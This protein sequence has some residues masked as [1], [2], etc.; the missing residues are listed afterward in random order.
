MY[1]G[2][3]PTAWNRQVGSGS[4]LKRA[5]LAF[6]AMLAVSNGGALARA[7]TPVVSVQRQP[8]T[9]AGLAAGHA[10]EAWLQLDKSNEP[11]EPGY[12]LPA[13]ATIRFTF[14]RRFSP[15]RDLPLQVV[16]LHGWPQ[17]PITAKFD[18][19]LDPRDSRAIILRLSDPIAVH[20]PDQPGLKAIHLRAPVGNPAQ[21]GG[22]PVV[23]AFEGAG[24]LSGST[25]AVAHISAKPIPNIAAYNQLHAGGN[26]NWQ[27]VKVG[28]EA[29]L[30]LDWLVTLPNE[31]RASLALLPAR[32][33]R[34]TIAA[35]GKPIGTIRSSGAS[36]TLRAES[37]GVGFARLGIIRAHVVAGGEAGAAE[38]EAKLDGG[39]RYV[40][41]LIIEP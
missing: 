33:G 37:L 24:A 36:L 8:M 12:Q 3:N 21:P 28:Q 26:E 11:E 6:I 14:P 9:A 18:V 32:D 22:Y 30:P 19:Y 35:D 39:A 41:H 20:P 2:A 17:G 15:K 4:R 31:A 29:P 5:A 10:F 40:I 7:A 16:L 23:V 1:H 38:I 25:Q 34:L 27:H 13:G